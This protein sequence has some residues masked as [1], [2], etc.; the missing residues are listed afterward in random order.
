MMMR[1]IEGKIGRNINR[2]IFVDADAHPKGLP[3][4]ERATAIHHAWLRKFGHHGD[5]PNVAGTAIVFDESMDWVEPAFARKYGVIYPDFIGDGVGVVQVEEDELTKRLA[6]AAPHSNELHLQ[7]LA[8]II[9]DYVYECCEAARVRYTLANN[10]IRTMGRQRCHLV[11]L[12]IP[13]GR[14]LPIPSMF[15]LE[16]NWQTRCC[17]YRCPL[18]CCF[19]PSHSQRNCDLLLHRTSAGIWQGKLCSLLQSAQSTCFGR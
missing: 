13:T 1:R 15:V 11:S 14:T 6:E 9:L 12:S 5:F 18:L 19:D 3:H 2:D 17:Q 8:D 10:P 7:H 16:H 4:N